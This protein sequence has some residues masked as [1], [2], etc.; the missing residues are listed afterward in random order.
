M[1]I[2]GHLEGSKSHK[3]TGAAPSS[4]FWGITA[5]PIPPPSSCC[6]SS[7][8]SVVSHRKFSCPS[9]NIVY[10]YNSFIICP[11]FFRTKKK[12]FQCF[13]SRFTFFINPRLQNILAWQC[14]I[15]PSTPSPY[16]YVIYGRSL[17]N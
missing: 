2:S 10:F 12:V 17:I 1:A 9:L 3:F 14:I 7:P 16:H 8:R 13:N 4:C 6:S 15:D 11:N 5:P